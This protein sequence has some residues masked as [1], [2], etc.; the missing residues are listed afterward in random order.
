MRK[1]NYPANAIALLAAMLGWVGTAE[2]STQQASESAGAVSSPS[3]ADL[4]DLT[5][6]AQ[7]V[8]RATI[9]SQA[10]VEAARAPGLAPGFAR[11]YIEAQTR[12]LLAGRVPL[13]ESLR[14]LVDVP[15]DA[16]G[17]PPS[18]RKADVLIFAKSVPGRP[19]ELQLVQPDAQL[20]WSGPIE[21][22][23]RPIL[24]EFF[25]ADAPSAVLGVRDALYVPG[26]LVGES[27]TQIFLDTKGDAPLS[28][29]VVRR[30][31]M[32]PSWG[33]S[34]SEIVDQSARPPARDTIEWYRLA[35][36]LPAR[37]PQGSS[38]A[39][40]S[41]SRRKAAEDYAFVM[42]Q[43]GPCTRNRS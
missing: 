4:A 30:P 23:L 1:K 42:A 22:R 29:S 16:K 17:K 9:K 8:V 27:E 10:E 35:C 11:L 36:F 2:A 24:A 20:F 43:L 5:D 41:A 34:R 3:Y 26:N 33:I 31:G 15:R 19:G 6:P 21:A 13:G 7:L 37:L 12:A 18:L 38:L 40:D 25:E 39:S 28:I 32:A 14:Y